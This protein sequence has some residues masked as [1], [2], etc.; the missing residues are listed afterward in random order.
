MEKKYPESKVEL[1]PK[2][3]KNYDKI[4]NVASLGLYVKFIR[5]AIKSMGISPDDKILDFGA[6]TGRNAILMNKYLS[7][8]GEILGLEI[9][10]KMI[11]QFKIKTNNI[12]NIRVINQSIDKP[13]NLEE[14]FDKVFI[15]FVL[16]GFP[17][18]VR[19]DI[20]RS[21]FNALKDGGEF[22]ILDFNEF[23]LKNTPFYFR[24]PFKKIECKYAFDFV[25]K[26]WKNIL[27][28]YGFNGFEEIYFF[29]KYVR[30]LK[31][32]KE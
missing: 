24:I 20:I 16:H 13:L 6:G 3:A 26:D 25:E 17:H 30:L 23:I 19:K 1:T 31:A 21:A 14:K 9:S 15:S 11:Q 5:K 22:I 32:K 12:P 28:T 2:I 10:E 27:H 4:M 8:K 7:D 18:S 29:Q